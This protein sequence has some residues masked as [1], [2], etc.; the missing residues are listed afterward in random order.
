MT[1]QIHN[2][3]LCVM[4]Q[5][6]S[7]GIGAHP[8]FSEVSPF[9]TL[10]FFLTIPHLLSGFL[11][12]SISHLVGNSQSPQVFSLFVYMLCLEEFHLSLY[13]DHL[14]VDDSQ[15]T[16]SSTSFLSSR[17]SCTI[18]YQSWVLCGHLKLSMYSSK[19]LF[20]TDPYPLSLLFFFVLFGFLFYYVATEFTTQATATNIGCTK[21][22][23]VLKFK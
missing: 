20:Y 12:L 14:N 13:Y 10:V 6:G 7:S 16:F 22:K 21:Q 1:V 8:Y 9:M 17:S 5:M 23:V 18:S 19:C 2:L 3:V 11:S 15:K 4:S